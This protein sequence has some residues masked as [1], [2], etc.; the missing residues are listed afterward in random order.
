MLKLLNIYWF[1]L[2]AFRAK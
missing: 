1:N 2:N